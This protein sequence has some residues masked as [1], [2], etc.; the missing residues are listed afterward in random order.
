VLRVSA[1]LT[2]D[3]VEPVFESNS[4]R[5]ASMLVIFLSPRGKRRDLPGRDGIEMR[6]STFVK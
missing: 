2:L 3:F 5:R 6:S 1:S 4:S